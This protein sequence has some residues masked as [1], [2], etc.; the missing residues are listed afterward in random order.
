MRKEGRKGGRKE[1][2]VLDLQSPQGEHAEDG[3]FLGF[4]NLQLLDV[5]HRKDEDG[6]IDEEV[7]G[8]GSHEEESVVHAARSVLD[9][10]VPIGRNGDTVQGN[11]N[12][13]NGFRQQG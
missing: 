9:G 4:P 2:E 13:L 1:G 12:V 3:D 8:V 5:G 10:L 7:D 11:G 6:E